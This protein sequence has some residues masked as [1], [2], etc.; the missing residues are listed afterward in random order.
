MY[1]LRSAETAN[2]R[3]E[4]VR[5][6]IENTGYFMI[7][8]D[9]LQRGAATRMVAEGKALVGI[10]LPPP[11][12]S[13]GDTLS[14]QPKIIVD[15]VDPSTVRPALAALENAYLRQIAELYAIGPVPS[16]WMSNGSI[17]PTEKLRG[18]SF[19]DWQASSL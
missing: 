9:G 6:T 12:S 5:R 11:D 16:R 14:G 17:I 1:R 7:I 3:V 15:A 4:K 19:R 8:A 10:E 2:H 18:Q 13:D